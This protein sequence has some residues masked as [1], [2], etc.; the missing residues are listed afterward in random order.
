MERKEEVLISRNQQMQ[1]SYG[2]VIAC[3]H[4]IRP[5]KYPVG[6]VYYEFY[7]YKTGSG[8]VRPFPP[9]VLIQ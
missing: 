3:M 5:Q 4:P 2:A 1:D 9:P 6:K 7:F 8:A